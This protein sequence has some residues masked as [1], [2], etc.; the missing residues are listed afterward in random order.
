MLEGGDLEWSGGKDG[1][2]R[3]E[4]GRWKVE[5]GRWKMEGG[6][7]MV[8]DGIEDGGWRVYVEGGWG[9][10]GLK[11]EDGEWRMERRMEH[12]G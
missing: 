7:W 11:M 4:G 9:R 1:E 10:V 5:D 12:G 2:W 3:V 6:G 8:E